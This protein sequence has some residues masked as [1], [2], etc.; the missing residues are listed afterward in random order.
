MTELQ[1]TVIEIQLFLI[2]LQL[3][4]IGYLLTWRK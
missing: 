1:G 2:L 3:I 4:V